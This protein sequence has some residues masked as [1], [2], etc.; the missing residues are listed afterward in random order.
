M[1][2][3]GFLLIG[4]VGAYLLYFFTGKPRVTDTPVMRAFYGY[5]PG[6]TLAKMWPNGL[7]WLRTVS[8]R[9][10]AAVTAGNV[11]GFLFGVGV[12]STFDT[13]AL[14]LTTDGVFILNDKSE[15]NNRGILRFS[16]ADIQAVTRLHQENNLAA[17]GLGRMEGAF[18]VELKLKNGQIHWIQIPESAY[19]ALVTV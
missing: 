13:F 8:D 1:S 15:E 14:S 6:E 19:S 18:D 7:L 11:A 16:R 12:A 4:G 10:R 9:E 5:A 17:S 3:I 2:I